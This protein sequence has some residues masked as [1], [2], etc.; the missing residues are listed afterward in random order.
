MSGLYVY[1]LQEFCMNLKVL[2]NRAISSQNCSL[3]SIVP[4]KKSL[5]K[6]SMGGPLFRP[7]PF[8]YMV[9]MYKFYFFPNMRFMDVNF[10]VF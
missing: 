2:F 7:R 5:Q 8:P 1:N 10:Y 9:K 3:G 4:P 6:V